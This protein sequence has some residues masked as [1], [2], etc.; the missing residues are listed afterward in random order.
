[1]IQTKNLSPRGS[2]RLENIYIENQSTD[3]GSCPI[4]VSGAPGIV[5]SKIVRLIRRGKIKGV[6][7]ACIM[8]P[9]VAHPES[10]AKHA[11]L[12]LYSQ[13]TGRE[14]GTRLLNWR[15]WSWCCSENERRQDRTHS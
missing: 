4:T 1:L 11:D 5:G 7:E 8:P 9:Y 13:D 2:F 12:L 6:G 14:S 15:N 10:S 3:R